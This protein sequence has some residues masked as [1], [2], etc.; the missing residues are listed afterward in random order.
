[1]K[2][3]PN[4]DSELFAACGLRDLIFWAPE[5]FASARGINFCC[6]ATA[7][8]V[9][10]TD[11]LLHK[12]CDTAI[13]RVTFRS[14]KAAIRSERDLRRY[15]VRGVRRELIR[16]DRLPS[17]CRFKLRAI[18]KWNWWRT[19]SGRYLRAAVYAL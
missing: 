18:G 10:R 4:I 17:I 8:C 19:L 16:G 13:E 6:A 5:M 9:T 7:G 1:M 12:R 3:A 2:L 15:E 14:R 11:K